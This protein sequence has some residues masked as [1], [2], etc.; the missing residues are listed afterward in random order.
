MCFALHLPLGTGL[1]LGFGNAARKDVEYHRL[2]SFRM[3]RNSGG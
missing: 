2:S 3:M 1:L